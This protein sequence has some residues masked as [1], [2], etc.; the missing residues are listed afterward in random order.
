MNVR[1][2]IRQSVKLLNQALW[3]L[4]EDAVR[5]GFLEGVDAV[6]QIAWSM[7]PPDAEYVSVNNPPE[8]YPHIRELIDRVHKEILDE[9]YDK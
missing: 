3:N 1:P 5:E 4:E 7:Y 6:L 2:E 8:P 9:E